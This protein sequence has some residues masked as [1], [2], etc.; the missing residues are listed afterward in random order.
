MSP[1][2]SRTFKGRRPG[3]AQGPAP[4]LIIIMVAVALTLPGCAGFDI[5][6]PVKTSPGRPPPEAPDKPSAKETTTPPAQE[7]PDGQAGRSDQE[8]PPSP[9]SDR[10]SPAPDSEPKPAPPTPRAQASLSLTEAGRQALEDGRPDQA[11]GL[12]ERAASLN[13]GAGENYFWLAEAW[14]KKGNLGQAREYNR[15]AVR[16][17]G[18]D[19]DWSGQV[20]LQSERIKAA[21]P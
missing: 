3:P 2:L 12:L 13:P 9:G 8:P 19:P 5:F 14:L 1:G 15:L 18:R 10:P 6:P 11:I 4:A 21:G 17:L 7:Q 20:R 16:Y